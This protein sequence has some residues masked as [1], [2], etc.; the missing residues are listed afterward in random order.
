MSALFNPYA[1]VPSMHVAFALMIG[2]PLARLARHRIVQR[3]CGCCTRSL[4]AFVIV[5]TANHFI[6]DALLGALTAAVSAY[7]A[8]WLARARPGAWRFC[9][10]RPRRLSAS[11]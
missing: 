2:W 8:S 11:G 9:G 5:V 4:M 1:A 6:V 3:R 7:G 10:P